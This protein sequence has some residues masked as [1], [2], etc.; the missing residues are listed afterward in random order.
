MI[1]ERKVRLLWLVN[2][3]RDVSKYFLE[4]HGYTEIDRAEDIKLT[5]IK[6]F[7]QVLGRFT[8]HV[9]ETFILAEKGDVIGLNKRLVANNVF[10][11]HVRYHSDKPPQVFIFV[12]EL[13]T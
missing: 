4:K 10:F 6:K 11:G 2:L 1:K 8:A 9:N 3:K 12:D 5:R 13:T 7:H